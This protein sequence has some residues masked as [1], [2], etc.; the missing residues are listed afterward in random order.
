MALGIT[1]DFVNHSQGASA[2]S[3]VELTL[4]SAK[5]LHAA[6]QNVIQA[7]ESEEAMRTEYAGPAHPHSGERPLAAAP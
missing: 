4:E 3:A 1:I 5:A 2:R 6:L 7:A